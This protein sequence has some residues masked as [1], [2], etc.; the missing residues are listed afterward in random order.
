MEKKN[1][2]NLQFQTVSENQKR[3]E[4]SVDIDLLNRFKELTLEKSQCYTEYVSQDKKIIKIMQKNVDFKLEDFEILNELGKGTS[5]KV[6]KEIKLNNDEHFQKQLIWE[7]KTLFS[8]NSQ[9][10]VQ[11]YCAFYYEG[12]LNIIL[13]Y[14]DQGTLDSILKKAGKVNET[15]IKY[16]TYQ[17]LKGIQYLHKELKIIH[18]DIK[19]GNVLVNS[20]G[21]IKISDLGICGQ[22]NG[23]LDQKNTF[24]GTTIYMSPE[25]LAGESYTIKTDIWSLG[26]LL[27][28][29]SEAKHPIDINQTL[30]L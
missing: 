29:I 19:P 5:G 14:M 2:L 30:I 26:L 23:T 13:E 10:I 7:I 1:K 17:I 18:R 12:T 21:E 9:Y 11:Y 28:E 27:I 22:V 25:R 6:S 16:V 20:Q 4:E 3:T 8:C 15:I 24:V